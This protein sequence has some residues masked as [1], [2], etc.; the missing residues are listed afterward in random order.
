MEVG[1]EAAHLRK[2]DGVKR[3]TKQGERQ[4]ADGQARQAR[5]AEDRVRKNLAA[6]HRLLPDLALNLFFSFLL[7]FAWRAPTHSHTPTQTHSR[8]AGLTSNVR[9]GGGEGERKRKDGC[10][11]VHV[12]AKAQCFAVVAATSQT[13]FTCAV[14]LHR[15]FSLPCRQAN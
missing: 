2:E 15:S 11:C 10:A 8:R 3:S 14:L 5:I 4:Q 1:Q 9:S 12:S 13:S 6:A 7:L